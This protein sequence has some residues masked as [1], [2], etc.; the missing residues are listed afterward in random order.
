MFTDE[1]RGQLRVTDAWLAR[2]AELD[3]GDGD[4][5]GCRRTCERKPE[6]AGKPSRSANC[7]EDF[8]GVFLH[9]HHLTITF[10]IGDAC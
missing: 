4:A 6:Q 9:N 10:L 3:E 5:L 8:T 1:T 2:G 7:K